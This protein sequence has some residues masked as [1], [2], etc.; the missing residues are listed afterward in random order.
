MPDEATLRL[1]IG[2]ILLGVGLIIIGI[3]ILRADS[4]T[5]TAAETSLP[6]SAGETA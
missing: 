6:T 4:E 5:R 3:S 2:L 1:A